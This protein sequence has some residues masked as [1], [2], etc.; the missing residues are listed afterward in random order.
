MKIYR[1]SLSSQSYARLTYLAA[2][3]EIKPTSLLEHWINDAWDHRDNKPGIQPI[4]SDNS[5]KVRPDSRR[6]NLASCPEE[7]AIKRM[8]EAGEL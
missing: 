5:P 7:L 1:I 2:S 3:Q 8:K 4:Q 6:H